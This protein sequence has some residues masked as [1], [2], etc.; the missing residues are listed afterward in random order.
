MTRMMGLSSRRWG[1]LLFVGSSLATTTAWG[2][3]PKE[4]KTALDQKAFFRPDLY[5]S[6]SQVLLKDTLAD[7]PNRAAWERFLLARGESLADPSTPV[8]IDPRSGAVASIV[9]PFP[10]IPGD[11][12]GNQIT[13]EGLGARLGGAIARVDEQV[14]A[15]AVRGFIEAHKDVLG[16]DT[17]QL[18]DLRATEVTPDLWQVSVP[19]RYKGVPVRY[20][21]L[22]ASISH[23]NLVVIGTESWGNARLDTNPRLAA[24]EALAAGFELAGGRASGDVILAQ[25]RLEIIPVAP[26]EHQQGEGF[27]GPVGAGYGHRLAWIFSFQRPPDEAQWEVIV[28]GLT[29]EV[30]AFEDRNQYARRQI[31]GGVYPI[32]NT[33]ICNNPPQCG[34]MQDNWPMPFADTGFPAPNNFTNSAGLYSYTNGTVHTTLTGKYVDIVDTC[35]TVNESSPNG[36]LDLGGTNG[37]HDCTTAGQSPGDTASSRSAFYELNRI[38]EM[39]RGYLPDNTWLENRL[40]TNVNLTQTCNAFWTGSSVNFFRSGGGCRNTGEIAGVFDHEWGHGLDDNDANF[41]LSNPSEAYADIAAILRLQTSCVGHGFW[42]TANQGCG[43]TPDGTGFNA[44]E[45]Q[46]GASHC[47]L[48]CSGVRDQDWDKHADHTP[49]TALGFVCSKCQG[50]SGPCGREVHCAAAPSAQSAWDLAARDLQAAPF[51][52]DSE[53]A[54]LLANK[55]FYQGSGNIGQW[56]SCAC[57]GT[58][59]GCG[60]TN[61]Y[62]QWLTADDDNGDLNDGTPHMTAIFGAYDRHGI[63]CNTPQPQNSG[64]AGGP[65]EAPTVNATA[66][67]FQV[68][69]SW[70]AVPGATRYSVFRTEG[71]AG[72][73]FGKTRIATVTDTAYTDKNLAKGRSYHYNVVAMDAPQ[74]LSPA[75]AC[76]SATPGQ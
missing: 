44:D 76:V 64:C 70:N 29:G 42:W 30:L 75:S 2:A 3:V 71:V 40:P 33:G 51:N 57:G 72:C 8:H 60:A 48:D 32:T 10:L 55:L 12:T 11:G 35:G 24:A 5:I 39:A 15:K 43:M 23:G 63:A 67:N 66:G 59:N 6:S 4:P 41:S 74:C 68:A 17:E 58:S 22:A 49:D 54:F 18:G 45:S 37:Q 50:G 34:I 53:T 14:V 62:M 31:R 20:G 7:L 65:T 13:L 46:V 1:V 16:I 73:D 56:H 25:P 69:L 26:P 9:A 27:A 21:R 36:F 19:Q 38:A 61:G 47:D 28:D 52:Y